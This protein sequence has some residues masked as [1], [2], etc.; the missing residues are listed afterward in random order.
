MKLKINCVV[1]RG[2]NDREIPAFM[3]MTR[4]RDIEVHFIEYMPFDG[5]QK[6]DGKL[7][8]DGQFDP[9]RTPYTLKGPWSPS[10][11][12]VQDLARAWSSRGPSPA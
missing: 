6:Q 2:R 4:D 5:N 9:M 10:K 7:H 1:I 12:N 8:G 3:E 11:R